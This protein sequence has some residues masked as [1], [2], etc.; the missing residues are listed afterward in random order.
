MAACQKAE[1]ELQDA[2]P[3]WLGPTDYFSWLKAA[4]LLGRSKIV[5]TINLGRTIADVVA[6]LAPS[7]VA[8]GRSLGLEWSDIFV[9]VCGNADAV[10]D[11]VRNLI[12]NAVYHAPMG[13]E[14]AV[15]VRRSV[16]PTPQS[17]GSPV[18]E[19]TARCA[20]THRPY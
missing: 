15:S 1:A 3:P 9:R 5:S 11:A 20:P 14:V 18:S 7:A 17:C 2:M 13:T 19:Q 12:E 8:Q 10:A 16:L 4:V 6:Y